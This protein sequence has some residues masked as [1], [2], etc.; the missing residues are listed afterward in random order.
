M[1]TNVTLNGSVYAIPAEGDSNWGTV[2]SNYFIAIG[3]GVLQKTGG[4]FTLTAEVDFGATFGLKSSYI[5][6]RATNP[7][8]TG[9]VRLGNT[10]LLSWRNAAN[11]AD[12]GLTVSAANALQ[13]NGVTL[14]SSG[15]IVNAD[16]AAGAAIAYSKLN[17]TGAVVNA[18][19]SA[20]AAIAYSK[21]ALAGAIVNA[22]IAAAAA[23]AY[24]K[25]AAL[26]I[27]RALVS[28]GSGLVSVSSVTA[29][30]LA[31]L[32]GR[33]G[34]LATLAGAEVL[35][36][37]TI[38]GAS[39]TITNISL[40][41]GVTGTL[42]IANGGTNNTSLAVTAGGVI[43]TDGTRQVNV[44]VGTSG[45][46]L[47]SNAASAPTWV[48]V[49]S[50]PSSSQEISNLGIATSVASSA[51][52]IALKQADGSTDPGAAAASVKVGMRS[53]TLTSGLYNQR[54]A[55]AALSLVISSGSTLGQVSAQATTIWVYLIDNAGALELAVSNFLFTEGQVKSTTAE[56]GAGAADSATVLY[57]TTART[58]VPIRLIGKI[59][60]TQTTAGT[61][62]SAGTVLQVGD[63]GQVAASESINFS[64]DTSTTAATTSAPYIYTNVLNDSHSGYAVGT[65]R[66]TIP[67]PG[68]YLVHGQIYVGSTSITAY[69]Y[70]NAASI[71]Q[72]EN[73]STSSQAS[74]VTLMRRFVTGDILDIRPD[75]NATAAG[76]FK[77]NRFSI[78]R[79]GN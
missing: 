56:G 16:V 66:Y 76:D 4:A 69:V 60:N 44:G 3:S 58:N 45:Q 27:S 61:W 20:S 29:T 13:F 67:A 49:A 51:L 6:S 30:E 55:T 28:D 12:L 8:S 21:L 50:A 37:K 79:L 41:A 71:A 70:L 35:T 74:G 23:I 7:A 15:L 53:A 19:V 59:V 18:D 78:V 52:T 11:S 25:L 47:Q 57:S 63:F 65:G 2:L 24:S 54:S 26:T 14:L 73:I 75:A 34:T 22:D 62:A 64:A 72:G 33:T 39:N 40:T 10:E 77:I 46:V 43:Y 38:S 31:L 68:F 1:A 9:I 48:A 32:S 5:K 42:P 17:L 36:N